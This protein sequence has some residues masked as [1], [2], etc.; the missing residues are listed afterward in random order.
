MRTTHPGQNKNTIVIFIVLTTCLLMLPQSVLAQPKTTYQLEGI[1]EGAEILKDNWGVSHIYGETV[2][3]LFFAQGFNAARDRL[4]QLDLWRK[5]GEGKLS[6]SFGPRFLE[7]D[8]AARLFIYR[9]DLK[10]EFR[11]YHP[12]GEKI[13]TAFTNGINAYIDLTKTNPD[14]LPLGFQLTGT[15]PGYWSQTSP[16]IRIFG[17]TRNI[18]NEVTFAMLVHLMGAEAVEKLQIFEPPVNLEIPEGIDLSLIGS[19]VLGTYN[20][21]RSGITFLSEDIVAKNVTD[22]QKVLYAKLLSTPTPGEPDNWHQS[23]FESNNWT[24][25]GS[26]TSTGKPILANDPHRAQTVPSLRYMAHLVGPGWNVIGAG[27]P[28]LPGLSIGHNDKIAYGLTIFS[29]ADEEDL[30]VYDTNPANP[31]QYRYKKKWE[32]MKIIEE[33]FVVKDKAPVKSDL[34]FTRHGPVIYEDLQNHKAYAVRAAYLEHEGTAVYLGSLRVDQA[35]NWRE[36]ERAMENHY[37]PSENMVYADREGNIGWF[38][39]SIAPIRPNW[40]GLL[41]V[42]GD[43]EYEWRGFLNPKQLPRILNP[44]EGFFASANQFNVPE[45]YRYMDIAAH[46]WSDPYR[47]N[48]IIEVLSKGKKFTISDSLKLQ[49]DELSLPAEQLVFLLEGLSASN[50]ETDAALA[51]LLDWDYVLSKDSV[52]AAIFELWVLQL[53]KNVFDLYVPPAARS[54]FGTGNRRV[55]I[56]L[57][58]SPDSVFGPDPIDGRNAILITSLE[59]ALTILTDKLGPEMNNWQWGK[60]HHAAYE[61]SLSAAVTNPDILDLLN[62]GPLPRGGDGFTVNNTGYRTSDF[63]QTSGPSFRQVIDLGDWDNSLSINTPGQSG[64]PYSP[65]YDDLFPLWAGGKYFPL[66]FSRKKIEDVTEEVIIL[67]PN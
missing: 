57:L 5:Q 43:G 31:L 45:D 19:E 28:A 37:T 4:W 64:N 51:M 12:D 54:I 23:A 7:K 49:L 15:T 10:K 14:L 21:S 41:P 6:E 34:K 1:L 35:R 48:R 9:G 59:E 24:I 55:L 46:Q 47:Y 38:G 44:P 36:F 26:L 3:D 65:H 30:Y 8:R 17:L 56:D 53:H 32:D 50:P 16:L 62:V 66:Y 58:Y 20:L 29:F 13:L 2:E 22:E 27:E 33:T 40:N 25:S 18:R 60:L 61:H 39:C 67:Q 11:S 63:R 52:P 42:P